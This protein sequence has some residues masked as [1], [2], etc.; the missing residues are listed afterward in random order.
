M[1]SRIFARLHRNAAFDVI[2]LWGNSVTT[3]NANI[4]PIIECRGLTKHFSLSRGLFGAPRFVRAVQDVT[5]ELRRGE[6]MGLVGESGCGKSTLGRTMLLLFTPTSGT[7]IVGGQN[8]SE[9]K[10]PGNY[11]PGVA[12]C[13]WYFKT[14]IHP[15]ILA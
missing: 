5:L 12:E 6:I 11:V 13:R 2:F 14:H 3:T 7:V 4:Q 15:W 8:L 9:L 1:K 10:I